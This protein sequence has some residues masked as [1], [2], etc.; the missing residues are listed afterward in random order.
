MRTKANI[1]LVN[2]TEVPSSTKTYTAKEAV[3]EGGVY[4][5]ADSKG[6]PK[7]NTVYLVVHTDRREDRLCRLL[8]PGMSPGTNVDQSNP[9]NSFIKAT[10]PV[11]L[12]FSN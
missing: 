6:N 5:L 2:N 1:E 3:D 4:H 10:D 11:T 12:T 8:L 9:Y 7:R